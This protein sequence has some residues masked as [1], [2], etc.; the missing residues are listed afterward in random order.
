MV[1]KGFKRALITG[2]KRKY[3][4]LDELYFGDKATMICIGVEIGL[5]TSL[6]KLHLNCNPSLTTILKELGQLK[7]LNEFYVFDEHIVKDFPDEW[8]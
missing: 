8:K 2:I 3:A 7:L 1:A 4:L 5:L 6:R